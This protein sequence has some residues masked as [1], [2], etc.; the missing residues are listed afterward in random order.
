[1]FFHYEND[2]LKIQLLF[3][4]DSFNNCNASQSVFH[5]IAINNLLQLLFNEAILDCQGLNH[6]LLLNISLISSLDVIFITANIPAQKKKKIT[7]NLTII[8]KPWDSGS[9]HQQVLSL[10]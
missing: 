1:M 8:M 7:C 4:K 3:S 6:D 9:S 5:A 2:K 10:F